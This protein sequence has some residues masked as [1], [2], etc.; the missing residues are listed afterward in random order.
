MNRPALLIDTNVWYDVELGKANREAVRRFFIAARAHDARMGIA[1][2]SLK[3]LYA[4]VESRMKFLNR[5]EGTISQN[6]SGKVA[7]AVAW[8]LVEKALDNAEIVGSDYSD[9]LI[10]V[11]HRPIHD[12]FEDC[13]VI[14]AA[15]RMN[16]DL[17]VTSDQAL[18]KHAPVAALS[19]QDATHWLENR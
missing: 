12:D 18:L 3:D 10:A 5:T 17:L 6:S 14:A 1:A 8:A 16:A 15:M 11:K 9:A 4:L 19:P 7:R 2:H 13:L